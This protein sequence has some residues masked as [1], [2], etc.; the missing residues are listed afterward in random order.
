MIAIISAMAYF[1]T[2][3]LTAICIDQ[4][5]YGLASINIGLMIFAAIV[6][7]SSI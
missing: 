5:R 7:G 6:F 3:F 2:L 1:G 4:R